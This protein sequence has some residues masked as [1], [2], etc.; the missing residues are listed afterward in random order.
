MVPRELLDRVAEDIRRYC[1]AKGY[2]AGPNWNPLVPWDSVAAFAMAKALVSSGQFDDYLAI[3]PEGHVYGYFFER[4]GARILSIYVDYPPRRADLVDDLSPLQGRRVLLIED[5]LV[6]GIS[7]ELVTRELVNHPPRELS[8]YLGR[9]KD[10]Q[11]V[12]NVPGSV[13]AVYLAED[14]LDPA[15]RAKHEA[16]F[17]NCFGHSSDSAAQ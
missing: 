1:A 12:Q 7:L 15:E 8:L 13:T 3:A 11:Q 14:H 2:V 10:Y 6:S 4:L 5:D 9:Q 16:D 17:V